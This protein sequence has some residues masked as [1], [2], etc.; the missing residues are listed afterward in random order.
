MTPS[1]C[2]DT[3]LGIL[4]GYRCPYDYQCIDGGT[5]YLF[6][7]VGYDSILPALLTNFISISFQLW[8]DIMYLSADSNDFFV[9]LFFVLLVVLGGILITSLTT[10]IVTVEFERTKE[11]E[12]RRLIEQQVQQGAVMDT[13]A[14]VV[15]RLKKEMKRTETLLANRLA[16][17]EEEEWSDIEVEGVIEIGPDGNQ[18]QS[19]PRRERALSRKRDKKASP[20]SSPKL[21]FEETKSRLTGMLDA[22]AAHM[23]TFTQ[24]LMDNTTSAVNS[25]RYDFVAKRIVRT[26]WFEI[27]SFA[28]IAIN[29]VVLCAVH[30]DM[31]ESEQLA[32]ETLN[33]IFA[34]AYSTEFA[35]RV[36]AAESI[37]T[38]FKKYSTWTD[39]CV[40]G[41]SWVDILV[42][43]S[44]GANIPIIS[45]FRSL[46]IMKIITLFP[47]LYVY[48]KLILSALKAAPMVTL[49]LFLVVFVFACLCMQVLGGY[50][51]NLDYDFARS[52]DFGGPTLIRQWVPPTAAS[53][54]S[55][56]GVV[57]LNVSHTPTHQR[58]FSSS[59]TR[60]SSLPT[61]PTQT[62]SMSNTNTIPYGINT[63]GSSSTTTTSNSTV[64]TT[65]TTTVPTT[66]TLPPD[67]TNHTNATSSDMI[68]QNGGGEE[69]CN[70]V[71][72]MNFDGFGYA[73][74]TSFVIA[75]GDGWELVMYDAIRVNGQWMIVAFCIYY[76]IVGFVLFPLIVGVLLSAKENEFVDEVADTDVRTQM[77]LSS[78]AAGAGD[79]HS[80]KTGSSVVPVRDEIKSGGRSN[81]NSIALVEP[82]STR[83]RNAGMSRASAQERVRAEME[84]RVRQR[85]LARGASQ[86][87]G[88]SLF[89][90]DSDSSSSSIF[91]D[92]DDSDDLLIPMPTRQYSSPTL[93]P[94]HP[95]P[96]SISPTP[97]IIATNADDDIN[98]SVTPSADN[99]NNNNT[100]SWRRNLFSGFRRV[101]DD[102][103]SEVEEGGEQITPGSP[104]NTLST[105]FL[106]AQPLLTPGGSRLSSRRGSVLSTVGPGGNVSR[107]SS[108]T[109]NGR[110]PQ[111]SRRGSSSNIS[112]GG[113][114]KSGGGNQRVTFRTWRRRTRRIILKKITSLM[115][116]INNRTT[117]TNPRFVAMCGLAKQA[118]S[119]WAFGMCTEALFVF[120]CATLTMRDPIAAPDA[121]YTNTV[122]TCESVFT[123]LHLF[124]VLLRCLSDG[125]MFGEGSMIRQTGW[126]P[127]TLSSAI[128]SLMTLIVEVG[129]TMSMNHPFPVVLRVLRS[130]RPIRLVQY[131]PSCATVLY[132]L[133]S[134]I[135][136]MGRVMAICGLVLIICSIEGVRTFRGLLRSCLVPDYGFVDGIGLKECEEVYR[137]RG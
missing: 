97:T 102:N 34:V 15:M 106:T 112:G 109:S 133:G 82:V 29:L 73:F 104:M 51:C 46:R 116:S 13:F 23:K 16:T 130:T 32:Q 114:Y 71:P 57:G 87:D 101:S 111:L 131:I 53:N 58:S 128:L 66:T 24:P 62:P 11:E 35:L 37:R 22:S 21:A 95:L 27:V 10:V 125:V 39:A 26:S 45:S 25:V 8:Y 9:T 107:T 47:S 136:H 19:P 65:S 88:M 42:S 91:D 12:R 6:G 134:S 69:E 33:M 36:I 64:T 96:P 61:T 43:T 59:R 126:G 103:G 17:E 81:R 90:S 49:V 98:V 38:F 84:R 41:G 118:T 117:I 18:I 52:F 3:P 92:S 7:L 40:V 123:A 78:M 137:G 55:D 68:I 5:N 70:D 80:N 4:S 75:T 85:I 20:T 135:A 113:G 14:S 76:Y 100:P 44:S 115:E 56:A 79:G 63:T 129:T 50:F 74:L 93:R 60:T 30:Q 120:G 67:T 119:S 110:T 108:Q 77:S 121:N 2:D 89:I 132:S 99:N 124:E 122:N 48:I 105:P 31:T 72:R 1:T 86:F 94:L 127:F 28:I 83:R 54:D